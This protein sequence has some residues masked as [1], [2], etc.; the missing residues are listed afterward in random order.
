MKIQFC[1]PTKELHCVAKIIPSLEYVLITPSATRGV[2]EVVRIEKVAFAREKF[3]IA[4]AKPVNI[5]L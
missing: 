1:L 3:V 4:I 5:L 2:L